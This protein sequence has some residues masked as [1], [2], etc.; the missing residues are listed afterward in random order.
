MSS[1]S[2]QP[3]PV[4]GGRRAETVLIPE[5]L[6]ELR[7]ML[8]ARDGLTLVPSGGRTQLEL[9][10]A[11]AR[12]FGLLELRHALAGEVRHEP[13]DLTVEVPAATTLAELQAILAVRGQWLPFDPPRAEEAT[14]GGTLAVGAGGPLQTRYGLPRD[15]VLGMTVARADGTLVKAGGRVVKNVTGYDLMRLWCGSF[16]TLGVIV[17]AWLKVLPKAETVD[18]VIRLDNLSA[19]CRFAEALLRADVRPE[20]VEVF[21]DASGW[22][23]FVRVPS[24]AASAVDRLLPA[25]EQR[26]SPNAL[27]AAVR[28]LGFDGQER[29]VVRAVGMPADAPHV[30]DALLTLQPEAVAVRP[31][32]GIVR[33]TWPPA[34]VPAIAELEAR[35]GALRAQL[36]SAGGSAVV[37]RL[38]GPI[39]STVDP[40]GPAPASFPL[41]QRAKR[42]FDPENRLNH[43]RFVGGI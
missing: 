35:L 11:P 23:L 3:L 38:P 33:A 29:L 43:G 34:R 31:L 17:S 27:Y 8:A 14:L 26:A 39:A 37:E 9:G 6:D 19:G 30:A 15:F 20:I 5:T 13:T 10:Y 41:M 25:V 40:W 36:R 12:P 7:E 22:R 18:R 4:I 28:D 42:A 16:G 32:A 2:L 21:G 24:P 1:A